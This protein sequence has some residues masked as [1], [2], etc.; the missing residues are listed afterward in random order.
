MDTPKKRAFSLQK[1]AEHVMRLGRRIWV[2]TDIRRPETWLSTLVSL[3][4]RLG[5][6]ALIVLLIVLLWRL[7]RSDGYVIDAFTVPKALDEAGFQGPVVARMTQDEFVR[8]KDIAASIKADSVQMQND[9]TP[10]L[11]V[12]V[13]GFGVSLRNIAFQLRELFGRPNKTIR[14]EIT[15]ADSSLSMTLRMTDFQPL[16]LSASLRQGMRPALQKLLRQAGEHIL[17]NYD[18]YRLAIYYNREM[19]LEEGI[20]VVGD[21]LVRRPEERHWAY[22]AWGALLEGKGEKEEAFKKF[23]LS[24]AAKPDFAL[25]WM[26]QAWTLQKLERIEEAIPKAERAIELAPAEPSYWNSYAGM[27]NTVKRYDEADR[28]WAR[29]SELAGWSQ[30]WQMNWAEAKLERG[31]AEGGKKILQ[32]LMDKTESDLV[33]ASARAFIAFADND[34]RAAS[35]AI[36]EAAALD[37]NSG[38][39]IRM[40]QRAYMMEGNPAKA[41]ELGTRI[42]FNSQNLEQ[43]QGILNFNAMA[44]NAMGQHDSAF[45]QVRRAIMVDSTIGYPY[46][47]LAETYAF[48]GRKDLFYH[49]LEVAFQK[50]MGRDGFSPEDEPYRRFKGDRRFQALLEKYGTAR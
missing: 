10:E 50:G 44:F 30:G 20:R 1:P 15:L 46:S 3:L 16:V 34:M 32:E 12:A 19:R 6:L 36:K 11:N 39:V 35:E 33:K 2:L 28:A 22:L 48:V 18:P 49:Y 27:L 25:P 40:A 8:V 13:M 5:T 45:A 9:D 21:M 14:G 7:I 42:R 23:E 43:K 37:P 29:V 41:V 47:T 17:G 38:F 4:L 31:D 26:R 24:V